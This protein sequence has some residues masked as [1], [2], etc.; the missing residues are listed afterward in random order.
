MT[1]QHLAPLPRVLRTLGI[2]S[3][4]SFPLLAWFVGTASAK[5]WPISEPLKLQ[6]T[7]DSATYGDTVMVAPGTYKRV[8]LRSGVKVLSEKGPAETMLRHNTFWVVH[9]EAVDSLASIEGFTIEGLKGAEAAVFGEE[10]NFLVR[11]CTLRGGWSG[12]R[13]LYSQLRIEACTIRDCQNGFYLFESGGV[14]VENDIQLCVTAMTVVSSNPQIL[15]NTITRNSL[16][17]YVQKHSDPQ[18]GGTVASANRI[19]NNAAGAIRNDTQKKVDS[20]RTLQMMTLRVPFNFWGSDCPDSALFR[21][22]VVWAPWVDESG[23][24]SLE[25]CAKAAAGK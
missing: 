10:S 9:G 7:I 15:R 4:A 8:K 22:S 21:G 19:W 24:R 3:L 1:V 16:G 2:A 5:T 12:V 25:K 11:N 20:V 18:I 13:M 14:I 6:E 23:T 17:L